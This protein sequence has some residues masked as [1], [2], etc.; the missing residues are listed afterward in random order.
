MDGWLFVYFL[1]DEP[2]VV[3]KKLVDDRVVSGDDVHGHGG[4]FAAMLLIDLFWNVFGVVLVGAMA[5]VAHGVVRRTED[6]LLDEESEGS[7]PP[8]VGLILKLRVG[9][10][11]CFNLWVKD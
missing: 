1:Y 9:L 11:L 6:L 8:V 7:S 4:C 5:V 10:F 3:F 2:I